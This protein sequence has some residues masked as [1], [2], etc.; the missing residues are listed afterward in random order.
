MMNAGE[1]K[2]EEGSKACSRKCFAWEFWREIVFASEAAGVY[3]SCNCVHVRVFVCPCVMN[4]QECL[5]KRVKVHD[6]A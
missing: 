1:M 2:K 3:V 5:F 4:M 6:S